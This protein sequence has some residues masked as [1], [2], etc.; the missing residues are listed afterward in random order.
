MIKNENQ[1]AR[2]RARLHSIQAEEDKLNRQRSGGAPEYLLLPL[3][4]E[5]AALTRDIAEYEELQRLSLEE[6]VNGPLSPSVPL[7]NIGELLAKLRIAAGLTQDELA[8][9]LGWEQSNLSRFEGAT[10]GSQTIRKVSEYLDGV[11]VWLHV[12]PAM[13]DDS[14]VIAT[15]RYKSAK[16]SHGKELERTLHDDDG[17]A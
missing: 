2:A 12:I 6:A 1:L 17:S 13:T 8:G 4:R 10:N 9:K 14:R 3:R 5:L 11:G 16:T 7:E 15:P